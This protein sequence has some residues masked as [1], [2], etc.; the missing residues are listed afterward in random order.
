MV[1]VGFLRVAWTNEGQ[2]VDGLLRSNNPT[3]ARYEDYAARGIRTVLNLRN[4]THLAPPKLSED[5][6]K[7]LG[8]TYVSFPMAPRRAPTR[9]ELLDLIALFPTLEKP[10]L[11]HCKS[12]ADRTGLASVIWLLTQENTS[13]NDAKA[14]LSVKY[15]HL[16]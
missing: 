5:T 10:I 9:Q 16:P 14:E 15:L 11:M 12:G 3:Q 13:L 4:D 6:C 8:M 2:V 7:R 1:D